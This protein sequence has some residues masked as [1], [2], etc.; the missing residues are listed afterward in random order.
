V[1][2]SGASQVTAS[3]S[4][5]GGIR[6]SP[7]PEAHLQAS[8]KILE[9]TDDTDLHG[10]GRGE[11]FWILDVEL[12]RGLMLIYALILSEIL[13]VFIRDIRGQYLI[14]LRNFSHTWPC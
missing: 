7:K 1:I 12:A 5:S 14:Y 10:W 6:R 2:C 4:E 13:S 3:V 8:I 11:Q 9:T